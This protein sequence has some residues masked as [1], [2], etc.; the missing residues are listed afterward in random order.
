MRKQKKAQE[1]FESAAKFED[2]RFETTLVATTKF[3]GDV[4]TEAQDG[5]KLLHDGPVKGMAAAIS[6]LAV[7][8][9][10]AT[11]A[12]KEYFQHQSNYKEGFRMVKGIFEVGLEDLPEEELSGD[13]KKGLLTLSQCGVVENN[14]SRMDSYF[15]QPLREREV[16][17]LDGETSSPYFSPAPFPRSRPPNGPSPCSDPYIPDEWER[18]SVAGGGQ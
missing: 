12:H 1:A 14:I 18:D 4:A 2:E 5:F 3:V 15:E 11:E 10:L 8:K 17:E 6:K 16:I 9:L 7:A 13:A